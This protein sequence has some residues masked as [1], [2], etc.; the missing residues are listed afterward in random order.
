MN[1]LLLFVLAYPVSPA[2]LNST[3]CRLQITQSR[4]IHENVLIPLPYLSPST[5]SNDSQNYM[6]NKA[7][8]RHLKK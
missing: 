2:V 8:C 5:P 6:D 7:I 3:F 4:P 1:H